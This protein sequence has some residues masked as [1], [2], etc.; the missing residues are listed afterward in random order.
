MNF[1]T[2]LNDAATVACAITSL[3]ASGLAT[4][5]DAAAWQTALTGELTLQNQDS[6]RIHALAVLPGGD[7]VGVGTVS[8]FDPDWPSNLEYYDNNWIVSRYDGVTGAA[9]WTTKLTG[10]TANLGKLDSATSVAVDPDGDI[11]VG[12]VLYASDDSGYVSA[13]TKLDPDTGDQI[14]RVDLGP[15]TASTAVTG[16]TDLDVDG[17][18]NIVVTR[19]QHD[20]T[21]ANFRVVELTSADPPTVAWTYVSAA[22]SGTAREVEIDAA[23]NVFVIGDID[24]PDHVIKVDG[25]NGS[26]IWLDARP[27]A[28]DLVLDAAG[29]VLLSWYDAGAETILKLA[30]DGTEQWRRAVTLTPLAIDVGASSV[31]VAGGTNG[32]AALASIDLADGSL[33]WSQDFGA[34]VGLDVNVLPDGTPVMSGYLVGGPLKFA[35]L[36]ADPVDGSELWRTEVTAYSYN[37][38]GAVVSDGAGRVIAGGTS[39]DRFDGFHVRNYATVVSADASTGSVAVC[40]DGLV[41]GTEQCD[42]GNL[43]AGDCCSS[44]CTFEANESPCDDGRACSVGEFCN[45]VGTCVVFDS[46]C[47]CG[48]GVVEEELGEQCDDGDVEDDDCCSSACQIETA[49]AACEDG[50]GCTIGE[51]CSAAGA[52]VPAVNTCSCCEARGSGG[53]EQSSCESCVVEQQI[54]CA[55]VWLA[56]CVTIATTTCASSCTECSCGNATL[57]PGEECEDGNVSAGDC[58]NRYCEIEDVCDEHFKCYKAK[59]EKDAATPFA[60]EEPELADRFADN[61]L[62]LSKPAALCSPADEELEGIV[63]YSRHFECYK[64]KEIT[65]PAWGKGDATLSVSNRFGRFDVVVGKL[66]QACYPTYVHPVPTSVDADGLRCYKAKSTG[67]IPVVPEVGLTD[68]FESKQTKVGKVAEICNPANE[69]FGDIVNGQMTLLCYKIKDAKIEPAQAKFPGVSVLTG[70]TFGTE[71]LYLSKSST[72]CVP[73]MEVP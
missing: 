38:F 39:D 5:G 25:M 51:T 31:F 56:E 49:G 12:G 29:N 34:V 18:G 41:V 3:L 36:A 59:T 11:L 70:N 54:D 64:A 61:Q 32:T 47:S 23:G 71:E 57:Q 37:S 13:V 21:N 60:G 46:G 19:R 65:L 55:T 69:V 4:P 40:G 50:D 35:M 6:D 45:G 7:I 16:V 30:S 22:T 20:G 33:D 9:E 14:W 15:A 62:A 10:G 17:G 73:S 68:L 66:S 67:T 2:R 44:T 42:D 48:N 1:R 58:C 26:Q 52:C 8:D 53:C 63:D 28:E 27:G 24:G 72:V 43:D